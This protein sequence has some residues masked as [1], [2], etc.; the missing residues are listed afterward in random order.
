MYVTLKSFSYPTIKCYVKNIKNNFESCILNFLNREHKL[1]VQGTPRCP[2]ALGIMDGINLT[3]LLLSFFFD[4]L[5]CEQSSMFFFLSLFFSFLLRIR[6]LVWN[7]SSSSSPFYF[8]LFFRANSLFFFFPFVTTDNS[9]ITE[10]ERKVRGEL[11]PLQRRGDATQ[12]NQ[13]TKHRH[14]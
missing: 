11:S 9:N 2:P 7:Q 5:P 6:N 13:A 10:K 14:T 4:F 8:F 3:A 12:L 1:F